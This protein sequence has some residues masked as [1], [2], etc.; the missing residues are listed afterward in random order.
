MTLSTSTDDTTP[1][2]CKA[3]PGADYD[4]HEHALGVLDVAAGQ[5]VQEDGE[6]Y[7]VV[8]PWQTPD[9]PP[10]C[11]DHHRISTGQWVH[12]S[13]TLDAAVPSAEDLDLDHPALGLA[14]VAEADRAEWHEELKRTAFEAPADPDRLF[15]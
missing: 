12:R 9:C 3:I 5:W 14:P 15:R 2:Y 7:C 1:A 13:P 10:G 8:V 11:E 6:P 4:V